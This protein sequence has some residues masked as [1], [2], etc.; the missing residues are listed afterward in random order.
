MTMQATHEPQDADAA[1]ALEQLAAEA[2]TDEAAQARAEDAAEQ[3]QAGE[4]EDAEAQEQQAQ[5]IA[6]MAVQGV[7]VAASLIHPGHS[8]DRESRVQGEDVMMPIARDFSGEIP[9][10]LRP[11][12]HYLSAGLWIGGVMVGAY[13]ARRA[14]DAEKAK[15][16]EAEENEGQ[17][18]GAA[19]G[20]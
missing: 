4:W 18:Q 19:H 8:L 2:E 15:E 5:A 9:E 1:N 6:K 10:W 3:A 7:E 17:A 12:M 13:R 14:E 16:R 20:V 11:Y